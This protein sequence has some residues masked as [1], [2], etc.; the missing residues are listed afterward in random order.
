MV[1]QNYPNP[2][3]PSTTIEFLMERSSRVTVRVFDLEGREVALILDRE[4]GPGSHKVTF[5]SGGLNLASGIYF[6]RVSGIGF[7]ATRKMLL[8]R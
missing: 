8:I 3:N 5:A 2:F 1:K 4:L 7:D 6:Y